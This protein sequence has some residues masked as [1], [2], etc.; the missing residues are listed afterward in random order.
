[1][2][3]RP[4]ALLPIFRSD[5][6]ARLLTELYVHADRALS[7]A[8]L[9]RITGAPM[10]TIHREVDRLEGAGLLS[11]ERVGNLRLVR[12][13]R[14]LPYFSELEGLLLKTFGPVSVLDEVLRDISG[15]RHAYIYGS[16]ARRYRGEVGAPPG[17]I[18]LLV[19]GDPDPD[20]IYEA[21]RGAEARLRTAVN[22]TILSEDEFK[23]SKSGF[24][25][26]I[27]GGPLVEVRRGAT[28][29]SPA[30]C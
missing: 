22:P 28:R 14:G 25:E 29:R 27:R 6:Q 20:Q 10:P 17:D 2:K 23:N 9:S 18:D 26:T 4:P 8:D 24:V 19:V 5:L 15:I 16:W 11:S 13:N 7:L 1:M 30:S 21:S 3:S 12:A